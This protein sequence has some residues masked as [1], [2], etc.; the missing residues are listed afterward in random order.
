MHQKRSDGSQ[1]YMAGVPVDVYF[2][3]NG[4]CLLN[5]LPDTGKFD[6]DEIAELFQEMIIKGSQFKSLGENNHISDTPKEEAACGLV[7]G[8]MKLG[9]PSNKEDLV[10]GEPC[11]IGS[12]SFTWDSYIS[13][14][15]DTIENIDSLQVV[16]EAKE[17]VNLPEFLYWYH[18][19]LRRRGEDV[20]IPSIKGYSLG[21]KE[22]EDSENIETTIEDNLRLWNNVV[23]KLR[24]SLVNVEGATS[25]N[26]RIEPPFILGL[27][28]LIEVLADE[29][30]GQ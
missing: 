18:K 3:G 23:K 17:L 12:K 7:V 13:F 20:S 30:A 10:A 15:P 8:R 11:R 6:G 4:C 9:E 16:K 5:W 19:S 22:K 26:I 25:D 21:S 29:W 1:R 24:S 14:E 27:K 2:G 28:A